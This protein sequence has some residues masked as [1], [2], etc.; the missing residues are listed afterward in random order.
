MIIKMKGQRYQLKGRIISFSNGIQ[1][2]QTDGEPKLIH[3]M[4]NSIIK[5]PKCKVR[6]WH[7]AVLTAR[8]CEHVKCG[9]AV[10]MTYRVRRA[11]NG[12]PAAGEWVGKAVV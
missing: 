1:A 7:G 3:C 11:A 6:P 4:G 8:P 12:D 2:V 9:T 5:C 10:E